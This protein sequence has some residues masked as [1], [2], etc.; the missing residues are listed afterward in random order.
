MLFLGLKR[1]GALSKVEKEKRIARKGFAFISFFFFSFLKIIVETWQK[2]KLICIQKIS[3]ISRE[4]IPTNEHL[5][6]TENSYC[7]AMLIGS[8]G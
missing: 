7:R 1:K 3:K 4:S 2:E 6:H 8:V 5:Q